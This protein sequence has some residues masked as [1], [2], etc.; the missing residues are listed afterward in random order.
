[1]IV[2]CHHKSDGAAGDWNLDQR[3]NPM[4][5]TELE[6]ILGDWL[7]AHNHAVNVSP[8]VLAIDLD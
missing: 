2:I 5:R 3:W 8:I 4:T 1:M 7:G 6:Q